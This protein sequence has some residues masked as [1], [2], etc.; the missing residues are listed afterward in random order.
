MA[1]ITQTIPNYT[2]G[3]S[4]QPD[5]LKNPGQV[6]D[7]I[8]ATPEV[9]TGLIKRPGSRFIKDIGESR[10]RF[11]HYY[12][13]QNEQYIGQVFKQPPNSNTAPVVKLWALKDIPGTTFKAGHEF[14]AEVDTANATAINQYLKYTDNEDLQFLTINDYTYILNRNPQETNN[15]VIPCNM[16][17]DESDGWGYNG[18]GHKNFAYIELKKTAN[19]RQYSLNLNKTGN[20]TKYSITSA[21]KLIHKETYPQNTSGTTHLAPDFYKHDG[22]S[23]NT[24]LTSYSPALNAAAE[25]KSPNITG[26]PFHSRQWEYDGDVYYHRNNATCPDIGTAVYTSEDTTVEGA[27]RSTPVKI[28]NAAGTEITD[29]SRKNL[30]WRFTVKG[31][32]HVR[33][34]TT[35]KVKGPDYV[36]TYDYDVDLL[37][38]GEGWVKG[39]YV[40]FTANTTGFSDGDESSAINV[41]YYVEIAEVEKSDVLATI[42]STAGDGAIRPNPTAFDADMAVSATTILGGL[43]QGIL[44]PNNDGNEADKLVSGA[45]IIGNGLY[46]Y[47]TSDTDTFSVTTGEADLMN[48]VTNEVNDVTKLPTPVSYTHLTLPTI[49]LV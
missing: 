44:D 36:C 19:A 35:D 47:N 2:S 12:R 40:K 18:I 13:D 46:I 30:I 41:V 4:E 11:F 7:V 25:H 45:E 15:D 22:T 10:H 16:L 6:S 8:N 24:Q 34:N 42:G 17:N 32:S 39:D 49:L 48:I 43:Q 5:Q 29:G 31:R 27:S 26:R 33:H 21:T 28:F 23:W 9:Q 20:T 14:T 3:I 1:S 37:H 38:G